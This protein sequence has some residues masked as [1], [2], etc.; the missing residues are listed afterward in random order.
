MR[1]LLLFAFL[2]FASLTLTS[3]RASAEQ[4]PPFGTQC[5]SNKCA[6][7]IGGYCCCKPY[8]HV[9]PNG[10]LACGCTQFC[11][12]ICNVQCSGS[13]E[14]GQPCYISGGFSGGLGG[15][16]GFTLTSRAM[17]RASTQPYGL[18]VSQAMAA[19]CGRNGTELTWTSGGTVDSRTLGAPHDTLPARYVPYK[20]G[21]W[22]FPDKV[23]AEIIFGGEDPPAP[24][25]VTLWKTG[26]VTHGP[27]DWAG[28]QAIIVLTQDHTWALG[29]PA[30]ET[31]QPQPQP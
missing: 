23:V 2:V 17:K 12:R 10:G 26:R 31:L 20:A 30:D 14:P 18:M 28:E 5:A 24:V 29:G 6:G 19:I 11:A 27:L 13:C 3:T 7:A 4:C 9:Q 25:K 16:A 8:C 21:W 15:D 22:G 1:R